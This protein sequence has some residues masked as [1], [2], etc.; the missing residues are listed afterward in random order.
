MAAALPVPTHAQRGFPSGPMITSLLN[1]PPQSGPPPL[2]TTAHR[3][4]SRVRAGDAPGNGRLDAS[5]RIRSSRARAASHPGS[6]H[7]DLT[8]RRERVEAVLDQ[9]ANRQQASQR[10]P[11]VDH[12]EVDVGAIAG[13]DI[14]EVLLVSEREGGEV[15]QGITLACL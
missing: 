14:V 13:D 4:V 1:S 6:Q 7:V 11:R 8:A 2:A 9:P 12:V 5:E 10:P 15:V 3:T